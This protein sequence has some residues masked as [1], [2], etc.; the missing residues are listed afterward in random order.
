M[1]RLARPVERS[2][3]AGDVTERRRGGALCLTGGVACAL[4]RSTP[5]GVAGAAGRRQGSVGQ[6][7]MR[8]CRCQRHPPRHVWRPSRRPRRPDCVGSGMTAGNRNGPPS[9][10]LCG[11]RH[12]QH[13]RLELN[14]GQAAGPAPAGARCRPPSGSHPPAASRRPHSSFLS[15]VG[16]CQTSSPIARP[17]SCDSYQPHTALAGPTHAMSWASATK[18][19]SA[20]A[21]AL[22]AASRAL[23]A[24]CSTPRA[25]GVR[26]LAAPP[27]P[28]AAAAGRR[29]LLAVNARGEIPRP[30][31]VTPPARRLLQPCAHAPAPAGGGFDPRRRGGGGGGYGGGRPAPLDTGRLA[32]EYAL[33]ALGLLV[34]ASLVGPLVGGLVFG[35]L[36]LGVAIAGAAAFFSLSSIFVPAAAAVFGLPAL[37]AG[38]MAAGAARALASCCGVACSVLQFQRTSP[39]LMLAADERRRRTP[40]TPPRLLPRL[41]PPAAARPAPHRRRVCHRGGGRAAATL[42]VPA[43]AHRRRAVAGRHRGAGAAGLWR[44]RRRRRGLHRRTEW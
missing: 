39:G 8:C 6:R 43:G 4:G 28:A 33:P 34:A 41:P 37:M 35:A 15:Y 32:R 16:H 26:S 36:G 24:R 27:R 12:G 14:Q 31:A 17:V 22:P 18:S 13:T 42:A 44:R 30:F 40:P 1:A 10:P 5:A 38:G 2:R 23:R 29:R 21:A 3:S 9:L 11:L 7:G 25:P 20:P 19:R